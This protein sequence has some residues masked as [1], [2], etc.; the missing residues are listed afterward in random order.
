MSVPELID[1]ISY[2]DNIY[3]KSMDVTGGRWYS[4]YHQWVPKSACVLNACYTVY[5]YVVGGITVYY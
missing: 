5:I 1:T 3:S 4:D 2:N